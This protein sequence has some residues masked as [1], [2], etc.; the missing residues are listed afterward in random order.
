M[1]LCSCT[2]IDL[3]R[4]TASSLSALLRAAGGEP[5]DGGNGGRR[6]HRVGGYVGEQDQRVVRGVPPLPEVLRRRRGR[7]R[8]LLCR[9]PLSRQCLRTL[10][11]PQGAGQALTN[12]LGAIAAP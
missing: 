6:G 2:L 4:R 9:L 5:T 1:H 12:H 10:P 7:A 11:L 3:D 8:A